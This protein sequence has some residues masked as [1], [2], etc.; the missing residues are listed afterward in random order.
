MSASHA[1][2]HA[3]ILTLLQR[4][5]P[6]ANLWVI[7]IGSAL[8]LLLMISAAV[9]FIRRAFR[10]TREQQL[11]PVIDATPGVENPSAFM[12]ASM[13]GVIQKLREQER[14]LERLHKLEK[15]RAD[16]RERLSE[17]VTRNMP[18]GLLLVN[19]TGIISSANP[20]A[21]QALGILALGFRR[22]SEALG[23][24]SELTRLVGECL[25]SGKI[26]RREEVEHHPPSGD[27][28]HLGVT[29][30]PIRKGE[31]KVT[32]AICLLSDLTQLAALQKQV[33]LKD[34]LAALGELS[35]GI[36][37]EFKNALA[38]ISGYAQMIQAE[39]TVG[40]VAD[41]AGKIL[42]QTRSITHVV[43]E[44][45]KYA[46]PLDISNDSVPLDSVIERVIAEVGEAHPRVRLRSEGQFG[47]IAGDEGLLRQALLNLVRNAAEACADA[48]NGGRV[49]LRGE[50]LNTDDGAWQRVLVFDN[51]PGI[52]PGAF[53][54]LFNPFF[55]T[56]ASGTGLGLAV[57]QKIIV[58]H[59]GAVEAHNRPESGAAFILTLPLGRTSPVAADKA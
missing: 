26:F 40:D 7:A 8:I 59:G 43:T 55:T 14:E 33:Q 20:A 21:E 10:H 12:T 30:S 29:I 37:H 9:F 35:A 46:R 56:K 5:A 2:I 36:A 51:G 15:E 34:N 39:A 1:M 38:T 4:S 42:E 32:G 6:G 3:P 27:V 31:G 11:A 45:L 22:Y 19:A 53:R 57:V 17:E 48:P 16:I 25:A 58:Q 28:R 44:F 41:S 47:C 52:A 54:K 24:E 23:E 13:Q 49:V 50:F 18:A